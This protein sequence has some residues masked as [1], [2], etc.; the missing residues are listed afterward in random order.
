MKPQ[1]TVDEKKD[2]IERYKDGQFVDT[3]ASDYARARSTIY[4]VVKQHA[5][6]KGNLARKTL[7]DEKT[8]KRIL[9][10]VR[11]DPSI[12]TKKI[13]KRLKAN[14]SPGTINRFLNENGIFSIG[15]QNP[16]RLID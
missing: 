5:E 11:K 6:R 3:I 7:F 13:A 4:K 8:R 14:A 12:K 16:L 9:K 1:L 10:M 2:I 15:R